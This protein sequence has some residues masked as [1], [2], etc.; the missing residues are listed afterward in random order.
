MSV[1]LHSFFRSS[2]SWRVRIALALKGI[3][4][5]QSTYRLRAGEQRSDAFLK[6]NPQ[7][8]VPALEIDGLVLTQSLA[9][10]EYLDDT[11]PTPPLCGTTALERARIRA[12]AMA[13]ACETHPLQNL[14]VLN[15][16]E[17]I[18]SSESAAQDWAKAVNYEGLAACAALLPGENTP[19]CFGDKPTLADICLVPQLANAR[20]FGVPIEWR[21]LGEIESNCTALPAFVDTAPENQ[22]DAPTA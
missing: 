2:A 20:R 6:I 21:R 9:I 22:P 13:I 7:G 10:I 14:K 18:T 8:L 17:A 3:D 19:F 12:F 11:I 5:T 1:H 16:V 4:F 15:K